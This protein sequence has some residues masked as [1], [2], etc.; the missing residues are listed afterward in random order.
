M[1]SVASF[2]L[3]SALVRIPDG[4][5]DITRIFVP[6]PSTVKF[7]SGN[8]E[9]QRSD[10]VAQWHAYSQQEQANAIG[11]DR[12]DPASRNLTKDAAV[13][14][15]NTCAAKML[16]VTALMFGKQPAKS[17]PLNVAMLAALPELRPFRVQDARAFAEAWEHLKNEWTQ[18]GLG[19]RVGV[20]LLSPYPVWS[21]GGHRG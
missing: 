7:L 10:I 18:G 15:L 17:K 11:R 4:V 20:L 12:P 8:S 5:T 16:D 21:R 1:T 3:R 6:A 19:P 2:Y 14:W 13:R 9:Q